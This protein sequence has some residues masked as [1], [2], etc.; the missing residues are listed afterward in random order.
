MTHTFDSEVSL[1][2]WLLWPTVG[3][4]EVCRVVLS[5]WSM[6]QGRWRGKG[7][8]GKGEFAPLELEAK[9]CSIKNLN[10]F[11]CT[12]RPPGFRDLPLPLWDPGLLFVRCLFRSSIWFAILCESSKIR[13]YLTKTHQR[14]INYRS[15]RWLL[16]CPCP[17]D[18]SFHW[19]S[20]IWT[21]IKAPHRGRDDSSSNSSSNYLLTKVSTTPWIVAESKK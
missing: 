10:V 17:L 8:G 15:E 9:T 18:D 3:C 13:S 1:Q 21:F 16:S 20:R 14:R 12:P 7:Q 19:I 5:G 2:P 11:Y 6:E 4:E